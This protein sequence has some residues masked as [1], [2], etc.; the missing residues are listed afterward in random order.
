MKR[1]IKDCEGYELTQKIAIT[2]ENKSKHIY[3]FYDTVKV[4]QYLGDE[5]IRL[6]FRSENSCEPEGY[7]EREISIQLALFQQMLL[8]AKV[9]CND[10]SVDVKSDSFDTPRPTEPL[11]ISYNRETNLFQLGMG[12]FSDELVF[13]E[14]VLFKVMLEIL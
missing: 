1:I 11:H 4:I 5:D 2:L 12:N 7:S 10:V 14:D 8:L 9:T 13:E 6:V 3:D